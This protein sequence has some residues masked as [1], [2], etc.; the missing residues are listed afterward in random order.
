[1]ELVVH[2]KPLTCETL[3]HIVRTRLYDG[4]A[5]IYINGNEYYAVLT[6]EDR[7]FD[8]YDEHIFVSEK[9]DIFDKV[10]RELLRK[11]GYQIQKR[12]CIFNDYDSQECAIE[13]VI[14]KI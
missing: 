1:M 9:Q 10:L 2:Q 13:L 4:S 14:M 12:L 7:L 3:A 8:G 5:D 6:L 11:D